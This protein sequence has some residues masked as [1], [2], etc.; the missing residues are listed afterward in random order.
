[1]KSSKKPLVIL[2]SIVCIV[3]ILFAVYWFI[4]RKSTPKFSD[5]TYK[6]NMSD[7]LEPINYNE[8][9][10]IVDCY[11]GNVSYT[12]ESI[13]EA[14]NTILLNVS[15]P[16]FPLILKNAISECTEINETSDYDAL[17]DQVMTRLEEK[18]NETSCPTLHKEIE[19]SIYED[20][21]G[22]WKMVPNDKF[23]DFIIE[24]FYQAITTE[25]AIG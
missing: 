10:K 16:D 19:L 18:L 4:I 2:L 8:D 12:V 23:N 17:L 3:L 7:F 22:Q 14:E 6:T 11:F 24:P 9:S 21:N 1:M 20:E 13:N 25:E 15:V 5:G